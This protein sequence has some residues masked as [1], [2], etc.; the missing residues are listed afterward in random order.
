MEY[1][2]LDKFNTAMYRNQFNAPLDASALLGNQLERGQDLLWSEAS[3]VGTALSDASILLSL[4]TDDWGE[5]GLLFLD[6]DFSDWAMGKHQWNDHDEEEHPY[7]GCNNDRMA[8]VPKGL[9]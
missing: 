5:M 9:V 2:R 1:V 3:Y 6:N 4:V 7:L 8:H